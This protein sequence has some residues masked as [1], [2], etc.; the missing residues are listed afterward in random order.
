M[1]DGSYLQCFT[2]YP[3]YITSNYNKIADSI[4]AENGC[5]GIYLDLECMNEKEFKIGNWVMNAT[6]NGIIDVI[7]YK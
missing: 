1:R 7:G 2:F 3:K 6:F 4:V 5:W